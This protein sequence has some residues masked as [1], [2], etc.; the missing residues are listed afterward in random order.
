M[1]TI[2]LSQSDLDKILKDH[3]PTLSTKIWDIMRKK[4]TYQ[5][6][7]WISQQIIYTQEQLDSLNI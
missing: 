3:Q 1:N 5:I 4:P 2:E 7:T 6:P